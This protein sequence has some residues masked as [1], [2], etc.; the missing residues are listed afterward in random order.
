MEAALDAEVGPDEVTFVVT[1]TN[2]GTEPVDLTFPTGQTVD[3]T[4]RR[5]GDVV[6]RWSDTRVFTQM[7]RSVTFDAG[8]SRTYEASWTDPTPGEYDAEAEV[9]GDADAR[10]TAD[11]SV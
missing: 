4:V 5:G 6:W 2:A 11:L 3:V 1:V 10:A 8:E 9:V 7:T